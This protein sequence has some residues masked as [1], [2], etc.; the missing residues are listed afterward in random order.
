VDEVHTAAHRLQA[1]DEVEFV[2]LLL[3]DQL[4]SHAIEA[5]PL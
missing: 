3:M 4:L 1:S 5:Q 2:A